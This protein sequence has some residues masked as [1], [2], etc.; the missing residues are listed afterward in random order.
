LSRDAAILEGALTDI[1]LR[2]A[3]AATRDRG[4][5]EIL[6]RRPRARI[7][8]HVERIHRRWLTA[9]GENWL[10]PNQERFPRRH[11][12]R[13]GYIDRVLAKTR[14]AESIFNDAGARA[15]TYTGF[16]S[17]DRLD[18]N[19][20]KDWL[21]FF[22]M[23]GGNTLKG[24]GDLLRLW[25]R[26]PDWPELVLRQKPED[27]PEPLPDNVTLQGSYLDDAALRSL[28]NACGIHLCP[29][30]S[31]GW[32]HHILEAMSTG[33]VVLTT[34]APPMNEIVTPDT[35]VLVPVT[36]SEPRHL[37]KRYFID[38]PALESTVEK[39][40]DM[41][42]DAKNGLGGAAR[43]RYLEIDR[44]FRQRLAALFTD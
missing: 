23:A 14:H 22:H 35:G 34:D 31:E 25:A 7:V 36:G 10:I 16:T 40:I 24:T 27:A 15:C 2:A 32:G 4:L 39:L 29:S 17:Q 18:P 44:A 26:H 3:R 30:Q 1:G 43:E 6:S 20:G 8:L 41:S 28:Q 9:G 13:L 11:L 5:L 19:T 21:R 12:G 37:G 33:G 42:P 38:V